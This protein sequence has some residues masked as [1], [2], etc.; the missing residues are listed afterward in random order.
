MKKDDED[1]NDKRRIL[2]KYGEDIKEKDLRRTFYYIKYVYMQAKHV[3]YSF[4]CS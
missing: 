1:D 2:E 4:H 3:S